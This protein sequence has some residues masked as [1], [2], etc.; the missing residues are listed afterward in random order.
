MRFDGVDAQLEAVRNSAGAFAAA[1]LLEYLQLA[2][3]ETFDAS[4]SRA[5]GQGAGRP[6]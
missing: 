5:A 2:I 1:D 3:A 4:D 6:L